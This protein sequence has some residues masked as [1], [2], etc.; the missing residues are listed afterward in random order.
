[1]IVDKEI[2]QTQISY[3]HMNMK[4]YMNFIKISMYCIM[5]YMKDIPQNTEKYICKERFEDS[6]NKRN[7]R[8][9]FS[10]PSQSMLIPYRI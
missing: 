6:L 8:K 9:S 4:F 5:C 3:F 10:I 7:Y 2:Y 1:M